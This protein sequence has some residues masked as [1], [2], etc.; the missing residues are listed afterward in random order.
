MKNR[1]RILGHALHPIFVTFPIGLF[2]TSVVFDIIYFINNSAVFSLVAFWMLTA[3][4]IGALLAAVPGFIDFLALPSGTRAKTVGATHALVNVSALLFFA[5]SWALRL[6]IPYRRTGAGEFILSLIGVAL[7][8]V[9]GW[10]GGELVER[11]G[12]GVY[13]NAN[14]DAPSSLGVRAPEESGFH[15]TEPRPI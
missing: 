1:V 9:G 3:G 12:V 15:P 13:E 14:V 6:G 7:L 5:L 11:L 8:S 10:L 2:V 4:G